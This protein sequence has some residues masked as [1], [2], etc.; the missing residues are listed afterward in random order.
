MATWDDVRAITSSLP[1]TEGRP[2]RSPTEW[3]IRK[4]LYAWNVRC[5]RSIWGGVDEEGIPEED[6]YQ[7]PRFFSFRSD[8]TVLELMGMAFVIEEFITFSPCEDGDELHMQSCLLR[9]PNRP[10]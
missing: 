2:L 3:R 7:P 8:D 5:V 9:A 6:F 1:E 4:K 10:G